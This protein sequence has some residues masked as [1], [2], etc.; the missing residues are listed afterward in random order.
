M[1]ISYTDA[2]ELRTI[3]LSG[4]MDI[5]GR[6]SMASQLVDLTQGPTRVIVNLLA[7]TMLASIGIRALVVSAKGVAARGGKI[8]LVVDS[9]SIVMKNIKAFGLDQIVPVCASE[10]DAERV[11]SA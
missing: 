2:G 11:A 5:G 6:E 4:R 1:S 9:S 3:T 7:I 10:A 8:V